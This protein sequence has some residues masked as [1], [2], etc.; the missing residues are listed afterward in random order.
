MVG[1]N[2]S[3]LVEK[4]VILEENEKK[5][6]RILELEHE[7]KELRSTLEKVSRQMDEIRIAAKAMIK[8]YNR[9]KGVE[10]GDS[11]CLTGSPVYSPK[12]NYQYTQ[13]EVIR[14]HTLQLKS[15]GWGE[16]FDL[17][18]YPGVYQE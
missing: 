16:S 12:D 10:G 11:Y 2:E 3:L 5:D 7:N 6:A 18:G 1:D 4:R 13:C 9:E 15:K 17:Q 8:E 14:P